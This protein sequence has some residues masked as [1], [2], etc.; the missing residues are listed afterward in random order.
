MKLLQ[1]PD[2]WHQG[3]C[4]AEA[5]YCGS[6]Y[7]LHQPNKT[8][9]VGVRLRI[10][11]SVTVSVSVRVKVRVRVRVRVKARVRKDKG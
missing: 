9:R 2:G 1:D 8:D 7:P 6:S 3:L 4:C 10:R 5:R 11:V